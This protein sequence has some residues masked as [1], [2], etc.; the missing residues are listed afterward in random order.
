MFEGHIDRKAFERERESDILQQ[1]RWTELVARL[2]ATRDLQ[3][4]LA[5]DHGGFDAFGDVRREGED[6]SKR[7]VNQ[8]DLAHGK[9]ERVAGENAARDAANRDREK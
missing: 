7:P 3:Q 5:K 2:A 8:C 4:E 1:F 6:E 9:S